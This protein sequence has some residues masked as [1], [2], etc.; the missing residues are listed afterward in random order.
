MSYLK[1]IRII[2]ISRAVAQRCSD[3]EIKSLIAIGGPQQG[4]YGI[5]FCPS[6]TGLCDAMRHLLR[7]GAY[8][9]IVQKM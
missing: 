8:A 2:S 7:Y 9:D 6:K 5:P 4:I 1:L 3:L